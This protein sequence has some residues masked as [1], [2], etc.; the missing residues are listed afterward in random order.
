MI[1]SIGATAVVVSDKVKAAQWYREKLGFDVEGEKEGHYILVGP[2]GSTMK[3][4]LCGDGFFPL[5]KGNTGIPLVVGNIDEAYSE[6]KLKGVE[7]TKGVTREEWGTYAMLKDPDGNE[8][9]L[10]EAMH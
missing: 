7:F 1:G 5:E 3:V 2:K 10:I 9:W 4:H 8:F 6:L